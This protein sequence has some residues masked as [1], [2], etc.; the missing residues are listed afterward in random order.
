MQD[1]FDDLRDVARASGADAVALVPGPNF[2]R[3]LGQAFMSHE[4]PFVAVIPVEGKPAA[5]VPNLELG[6]W[7]QV[8]FDGAVYDW[9]D[10]DGYR[11]AFAA[12]A[13]EMPLKSL[14]VE[15]QVM[16][17]FV[18]HAFT[19]ALPGVEIIDAERAISGLRMVKTEADIAALEEAIGISERALARARGA[20]ERGIPL[21]KA[22]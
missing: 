9:R 19:N 5:I 13:R 12:L 10:Q 22:P 3:A 7:A 16:R 1:Q 15:G 4:R 21:N 11:P 8:D 17:V 20:D 2:T 6:S 18:H 14:A